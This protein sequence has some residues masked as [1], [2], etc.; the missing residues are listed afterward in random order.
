MSRGRP[1]PQVT[2]ISPK[3]GVPWTKVT[4]RGENLGTSSQD[5]IGLTICGHNCL[6]TADWISHSKIICRTGPAKDDRGDII[7]T[8]RLGGQGTSTVTFRV[9]KFIK[10]DILE[11]SAVW[12][13]EFTTDLRPGRNKIASPLSLR[14]TNPLGIFMDSEKQISQ[15]ELAEMFPGMSGDFTS[16][17]FSPIWYL[18]ENHHSCSFNTLKVGASNL[19]KQALRKDEGGLSCVKGGL[20]TFFEAQDA[21]SAIHQK[22]EKEG[23][24]TVEG[25]MTEDVEYIL[26]KANTCADALF[27]DVLHRKDKADATRNALGILQRFKFL[28]NLPLTI[29][30]NIQK[31]DYDV[32]INDYEKAKSLFGN[33]EVHIFQKVYA[34]VEIRI[35]SLQCLLLEKLLETPSTLHDQKRY[36]RYLSDIRAPGDPAWQCIVGQHH[37]L[38]QLMLGCRERFFLQGA[39]S[40]CAVASNWP[41]HPCSSATRVA[42]SEV[43]HRTDGFHST[44]VHGNLAPTKENVQP[45]VQ[46]AEALT[47]AVLSHLPSLWKL[48]ICYVNGS[49]FSETGEKSDQLEKAKRIAR[50]KQNDFRKMLT[51]LLSVLVKLLRGALLSHS[52]SGTDKTKYGGWEGYGELKSHDI[53]RQVSTVRETGE[54]LAGLDIPAD[55][56]VGLQDLTLD[57]RIHA[58]TV[59]LQHAANV[60]QL[61]ITDWLQN[62]QGIASLPF[63][64]EQHIRFMLQSLQDVVKCKPGEV[65]VFLQESNQKMVSDMCVNIMQAFMGCLEDLATHPYPG[66]DGAHFTQELPSRHTGGLNGTLPSSPEERLLLVLNTCRS[67]AQ[68]D[69]Q[70]LAQLLT[71]HEFPNPNIVLESGL[72]AVSH[73]DNKLFEDYVEKKADP[74][75]GALEPGMYAGYFDWNDC[76]APS[77]VRNYLKELLMGLT[78][79]HAEVFAMSRELVSRVLSR[80]IEGVAEE[81]ARLLQCVHAFST[82]GTVQAHLEL[83]AFQHSTSAFHTPRS[84]QSFKQAVT[85]LPQINTG[86]DRKLM[87]DLVNRF[88][89]NMKLQLIC[90]QTVP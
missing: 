52:M 60:K 17:T 18:I 81:M 9:I 22:L 34:E 82:H 65:S 37:W 76:L 21:L 69:F 2:G 28:F 48:W 45:Q 15:E 36:I 19:R 39:E 47:N 26:D 86:M 12:L 4:I 8:T 46:F 75:V 5:L 62:N 11:P 67:L 25:S 31:G 59:A 10:I 29:D 54:G 58:V 6:L 85:L 61:A 66:T 16:E 56:L 43:Q 84:R 83:Y 50:Q 38:L 74:L 79:V 40:R 51:E 1:T 42:R 30:R 33:T 27:Q 44:M 13:E 70:A 3:E 78:A 71:M 63:H 35:Q 32:V 90:F 53:A 87:A 49:L 72:S 7:V 77:G 14:P 41:E 20:G 55:M 68:H 73:L 88:K 89:N 23:T 57:L 24:K 80:L 64:F